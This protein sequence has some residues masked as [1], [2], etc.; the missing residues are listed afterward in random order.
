MDR[1]AFLASLAGLLLA[2]S[3]TPAAAQFSDSYNFLKAVRDA[4][5]VA[6]QKALDRAG[7]T[8]INTRDYSTG[9][10]GLHITIKRRDLTWTRFLLARGANPDIKDAHGDTPLIAATR[11]GFAQ[12]AELLIGQ[13]A[14]INLG[15]SSG[16]TP[17]IIA[18]QQR[19]TQMVRLLL[20]YGADPKQADRIAGKSARDYASED[21]RSAAVLKIIDESKAPVQAKPK[22]A[23]PSL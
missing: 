17:L 18:T 3:S 10:S 16:E 13:R 23:G 1:R 8:L 5:G 22:V 4:D 6:A 9:E 11:L 21:P 12:G 20:S 14:R 2:L 15:N 19:N 7:V